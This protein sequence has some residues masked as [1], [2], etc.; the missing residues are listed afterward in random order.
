[1]TR[2]LFC[3][4][5]VLICVATPSRPADA[6]RFEAAD[7]HVSAP[8]TSLRDNFTQGPFVGG[9]R[10]E[11]RKATILDL[12]RL[13][14]SIQ[15]DK[16]VGGPPWIGSDRFDILAKTLAGTSSADLRLMLQDVLGDRFSLKVHKDTKPM[17]AFALIMAPSKKLH[18]KEA[19]G[20][21]ETGCKGENS[22][23]GE[24]TGR[25]MTSGPDG[26]VTTLSI[27]LGNLVQYNCRNMTMSAFVAEM[28]RF[29]GANI[30]P[31]PV[32]DETG[33]KGKWNFELKFSF[34]LNGAP[35]MMNGAAAER[36][37]FADA[38]EKELGLRL[39][40]R[41][42]PMPV[43]VVDSVD[44]KPTPNPAGMTLNLP[45]LPTEF[46]VADIKPTPPDFRFGNFR[47]PRGG[48]V[49]IQGMPLRNLIQQA[50]NIYGP[51]MIVGAPKFVETDRYNIIAKAPTY[52]AEPDGTG[53]PAE[54]PRFQTIDQESINVMLR[55][56]LIDRFGIKYHMEERPATAFVLTA[57]KP[58]IKKADPA[59]RSNCREGTGLDGKD[60]R[61]SNPAAGRLVTCLN[62][63]MKQFAQNLPMLA[64]GYIQG[65]TVYDES[66]IEGAFD[67]TLNFS[68][69]GMVGGPGRG[70]RGDGGAAAG[71]PEATEP[72]GAI[73]I[74]DAVESSS[75]LSWNVRS[76]R[77]RFS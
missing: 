68:P 43:I 62:M 36:I 21:G 41:E 45:A 29:L 76:G 53:G 18:L 61:V 47:I 37:P 11:I 8:A 17:P 23:S 57:G 64:G 34:N 60:P 25:L 20:S 52:G 44:E 12:I 39:D 63:T 59:N 26:V 70:G 65:A 51:D 16:I 32:A 50:W 2:I 40:K 72:S 77:R 35:M 10:F 42:V 48:R 69:I 4:A 7:V 54:G 9:G 58:K 74:F 5:V 15:T 46:E 3:S 38:L 67:F 27:L 49:E 30:G 75:A 19:D 55:N 14:W 73:S 66:G 71:V 24:G 56:L 6:P 28:G 13:G 22:A 31:N 33:L 1:M